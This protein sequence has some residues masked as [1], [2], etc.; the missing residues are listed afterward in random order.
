MQA[1]ADCRNQVVF[2]DAKAGSNPKE[3]VSRGLELKPHHEPAE[4][5]ELL[6]QLLPKNNRESYPELLETSP[7][8]RLR[9]KHRAHWGQCSLWTVR[10]GPVQTGQENTAG[11]ALSAMYTI[12]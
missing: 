8:R 10:P 2:L 7:S 12:R 1:D 9:E 11:I 5:A 6:E 3:T 4:L